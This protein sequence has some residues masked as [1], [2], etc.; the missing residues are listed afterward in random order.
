MLSEKI[1]KLLEVFGVSGAQAAEFMGYSPSAFSRIKTGARRPV[2][3]SQAS[4]KLV[5]GFCLM[6]DQRDQTSLLRDICHAPEGCGE[7]ELR[8]RLLL[9]LFE[10]DDFSH[11]EAAG[12]EGSTRQTDG[13]GGV[14]GAGPLFAERL[15]A[16]MRLA[17][18][19]NEKLSRL[20]FVH[21]SYISKL[22]RGI[23]IPKGNSSYIRLLCEALRDELEQEGKQGEF[24]RLAGMEN[25]VMENGIPWT[26]I[27]GWLF[28]Y[29]NDR[30][31][32]AV[33]R[34]LE[35]L[36]V[37]MASRIAF[38]PEELPSLADIRRQYDSDRLYEYHGIEGMRC[39]VVRF[40]LEAFDGGAERIFLYSDQDMG[41]M[42]E[43]FLPELKALMLSCIQKGMQIIIIHNIGR[44]AGE[45]FQAISFWAPLYLSSQIESYY[46]EKDVNRVFFHTL[47]LNPGKACI[48]AFS[49]RGK[50]AGAS[51]RYHTDPRCLVAFVD[52]FESFL[53]LAKPLVRMVKSGQ[54]PKSGAAQG[55]GFEPDGEIA[56]GFGREPE[57]GAAQGFGRE[58]ESGI[59][60]ED[61]GS[62]RGE[63]EGSDGGVADC[64]A[65]SLDNVF[66]HIFRDRVV[67]TRSVEPKISIVLT[68]PA[69][70]DAFYA[71]FGGVFE[72]DVLF[73]SCDEL[74]IHIFS[75][76]CV[77][78][79]LY[80]LS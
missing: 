30:G 45:L 35:T 14:M 13:D 24:C 4:A 79:L 9:W 64:R 56:Q 62:P 16:L 43:P 20:T 8:Q 15:D 66:V 60:A 7:D 37:G 71:F 50:E 25:S 78:T 33:G 52:A 12:A 3:T 74:Y 5:N 6:A 58:P 29:G 47:F 31:R 27:R 11:E 19:S 36:S 68:H 51:Y 1:T 53:Q 73:L 48:E 42:D 23:R 72:G 57:S 38:A 26:A 40:L 28:D 76:I 69:M 46:S 32:M 55:F 49:I 10:V 70:R 59:A 63:M 44:D 75:C 34:L 21:S 67:V 65:V 54:E 77:Q 17:D 18:M 22:R 39:A 2:I 41:W 61:G 80:L